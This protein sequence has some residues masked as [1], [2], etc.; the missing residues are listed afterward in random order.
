M[1]YLLNVTQ[2]KFVLLS[3]QVWIQNKFAVKISEYM[4]G[5]RIFLGQMDIIASKGRWVQDQSSITLPRQFNTVDFPVDLGMD[6]SFR[7]TRQRS[8]FH[9]PKICGGVLFLAMI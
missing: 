2:L 8:V 4:C 1:N 7:T 6:L 3:K 5:S 9:T